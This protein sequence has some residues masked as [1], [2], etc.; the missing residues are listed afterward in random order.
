MAAA[1]VP[2]PRV[3]PQ[4]TLK[5]AFIRG[6]V[7]RYVHVPSAEVDTSL[8]QDAARK[9]AFEAAAAAAKA[10]EEAPAA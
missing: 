2:A 9:E 10:A 5:S 3:A 7:V 6:S 8:L 4:T 1:P